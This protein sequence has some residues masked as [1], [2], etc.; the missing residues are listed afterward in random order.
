MIYLNIILMLFIIGCSTKNKTRTVIVPS[1]E[2][3]WLYSP[4]DGCSEEELCASSEGRKFIE[5]DANAKK[6]LASIFETKINAEFNF[7]KNSFSNEEIIE[8]R[9]F[10]NSEVNEQVEGILKGASIKERFKKDGL[11]FSLAYLNKITVK[12]LISNEI[13][14]I[15]NELMHFYNMKNRL[16]LKKMNLLYNQRNILNEK[17]I[18]VASS[19]MQSPINFSQI[20]SLKYKSIGG[21]KVTIKA[22]NNVP[23]FLLK[24]VEELLSDLGYKLVSTKNDYYL[25]LSYKKK[26]E[27]LNVK[28]FKK[29]TFTINVDTKNNIGKKLGSFSVTAVENGRNKKDAFL[30]AKTK[31]LNEFEVKLEKL[32]FK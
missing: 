29:Y 4:Q 19:G 1:G 14:R 13:S 3:T 6:S 2:P 21:S 24:K 10:V 26:E 31:L 23:A 12:K 32:N 15:D 17:M 28:G 16:F 27:Y 22:L 8:M 18:I 20:N 30:K 5:S 9:E 11:K 7:T 25:N